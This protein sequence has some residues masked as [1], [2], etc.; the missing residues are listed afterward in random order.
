MGEGEVVARVHDKVRRAPQQLGGE[1]VLE[2]ALHSL[3]LLLQA[4]AGGLFRPD[5]LLAEVGQLRAP[6]ALEAH[7]RPAYGLL[8]LSERAPNVAIREPQ[9]LGCFRQRSGSLYSLE[10]AEQER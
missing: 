4:R 1:L 2:V 3:D 6:A 5:E 9:A 10:Q 7:Q 8:P